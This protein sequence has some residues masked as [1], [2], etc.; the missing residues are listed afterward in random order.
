MPVNEPKNSWFSSFVAPLQGYCPHH[1][2]LTPPQIVMKCRQKATHFFPVLKE[3]ENCSN[4]SAGL[5]ISSIWTQ[6][7]PSSMWLG[8]CRVCAHA[9]VGAPSCCN[10]GRRGGAPSCLL[11]FLRQ[12]D[13]TCHEHGACLVATRTHAAA[14]VS[15]VADITHVIFKNECCSSC[16][17]TR[18]E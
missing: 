2:H 6:G 8:R 10:N 3:I 7:G 18:V 4:H 15:M 11:L 5:V 17:T 16:V 13:V 14:Q 1:M 9:V 12:R